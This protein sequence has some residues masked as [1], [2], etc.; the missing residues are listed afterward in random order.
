MPELLATVNVAPS[1]TGVC[2]GSVPVPPPN[3]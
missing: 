1:A 3:A 2:D